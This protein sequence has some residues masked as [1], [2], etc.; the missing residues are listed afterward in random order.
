VLPSRHQANGSAVHGENW[1]HT[2]G[3]AWPP[4]L[5][6]FIKLQVTVTLPLLI[7]LSFFVFYSL[8]VIYLTLAVFNH[9]SHDFHYKPFN[10][11]YRSYFIALQEPLPRV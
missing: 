5:L 10:S 2:P 11:C 1:L 7:V 9:A 3:S 8:Y 4:V 6:L